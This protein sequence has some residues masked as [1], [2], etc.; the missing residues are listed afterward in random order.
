MCLTLQ[1]WFWF[2]L[3]GCFLSLVCI[4][5]F[6]R[7][8]VIMKKH[9]FPRVF[10]HRQ[11]YFTPI[12]F[13]TQQ[14]AGATILSTFWTPKDQDL[15]LWQPGLP[16]MQPGQGQPLGSTA[17]VSIPQPQTLDPVK[18]LPHV[19]GL[20]CQLELHEQ[21]SIKTQ[22]EYGRETQVADSTCYF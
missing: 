22:D 20:T 18:Y 2:G 10:F 16:N 15:G 17:V 19:Q 13:F 7:F 5:L 21:K 4:Q 12:Y 6:F 14:R 9:T 3:V 8:L 1:S 11:Y